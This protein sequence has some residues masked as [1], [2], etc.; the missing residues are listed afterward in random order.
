MQLFKTNKNTKEKQIFINLITN[1]IA[2]CFSMLIS[3]WLTPYL[4]NKLGLAAYG[5]IGLINNISLFMSL[6]TYSLTSM[7]GRFLIVSMENAG[8][9]AASKYI[10][11]ALFGNLFFG[12]FS[13]PVILIITSMLERMLQIQKEFIFDVKLAFFLSVVAFLLNSIFMVLSTGAYSANRLDINNGINILSNLVRLAFLIVI[14][15]VF[16]AKIWHVALSSFLQV[17]I[18]IILAYFSFKKLLPLI[19]F[20]IRNFNIA[21][22]VEL[23]SSGFLNSIVLLGNLF[24]TQIDLIVGNR[25][26]SPEII[27]MYAAILLL[28][29]SIRNIAM[30]ISSAFTPTTIS[31]YSSGDMKGLRVYSNQVVKFCGLLIGWPVAIIS[32]LSIPIISL[33]LGK[34]YSLY[35]YTIILMLLP[36]T[37]H[38]AVNQLHNVQQAMNK[39]KVP[40]IVSVILGAFNIILAIFLTSR[41]H[42][43]ILGI[44]LSGITMSTIR[45]VIF[46]PIYTSIITNQSK[47]AY[48][49]GLVPPLIVASLTC[50]IGIYLQ[51]IV[52]VDSLF[53][54]FFAAVALSIF[55]FSLSVLLLNRE[56]RKTIS[57][58]LFLL[59]GKGGS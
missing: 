12:L 22:S 7:V 42:M 53:P 50:G 21:N 31:L 44:V 25:F 20:S 38:L 2:M 8:T 51:K 32:G 4:I 15:S 59:I 52:K 18:S 14:F 37:L 57:Q 46:L 17:V 48:Y 41:M 26:L 11:S 19:R 34:D 40:A 6:I 43:G 49:K 56:D 24:L 3:I 13:I 23:F 35:Q 9:N 54:I 58:K 27:G 30:A 10:S 1:I 5:Y 55:Y 29:N 36:L 28:P 33:W 16:G 45:T 47:L 39:V